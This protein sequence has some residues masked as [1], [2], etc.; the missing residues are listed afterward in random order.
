[1]AKTYECIAVDIATQD[2]KNWQ[3]NEH[4]LPIAKPDADLIT[5]KIIGFMIFVFIIKQIKKSVF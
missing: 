4:S 1:M 3:V 5:A 2:C